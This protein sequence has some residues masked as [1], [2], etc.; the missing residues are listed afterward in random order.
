[1][2]RSYRKVAKLPICCVGHKGMK[3]WK[4]NSRRG[5]RAREK[6]QMN[7]IVVDEEGYDEETCT[8][9]KYQKDCSTNDWTGPHDGWR[10]Y[11]PKSV[12]HIIEQWHNPPEH[13]KDMEPPADEMWKIEKTRYQYFSK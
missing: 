6:E 4:E 8:P 7:G 10:T 1:M 13:L 12:E 3:R 2:S 5:R 9:I 11:S